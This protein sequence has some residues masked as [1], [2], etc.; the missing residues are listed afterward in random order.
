M[1]AAF[2]DGIGG[3][4][5]QES[6]RWRGNALYIII[7]LGDNLHVVGNQVDR[8]K[9]DTKLADEVKVATLLHLL[10]ECCDQSNDTMSVVI[11]DSQTLD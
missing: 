11:R 9:P 3:V 2:A 1:C 7:M 5:E 8:V 4:G 10:Q 6:G